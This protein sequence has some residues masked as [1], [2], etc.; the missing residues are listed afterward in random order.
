METKGFELMHEKLYAMVDFGK[1]KK[2]YIVD[3]SDVQFFLRHYSSERFSFPPTIVFRPVP[4][5][6]P[7]AFQSQLDW[8]DT[9]MFNPSNN[10]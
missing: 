4:V 10:N 8:K 9:S 7:I 1:E 5:Y 2:F 3:Y 6:D